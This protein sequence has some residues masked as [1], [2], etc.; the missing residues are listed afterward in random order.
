MAPATASGEASLLGL[1]P[2]LRVRIYDELI[3][4]QDHCIKPVPQS[5]VTRTGCCRN[6]WALPQ[7][8]TLVR[9]EV[10][11]MLPRIE[12]LSFEIK[13]FSHRALGIWLEQL[14]SERV[15]LIRRLEMDGEGEFIAN[16]HSCANPDEDCWR[17]V[18]WFDA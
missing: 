5:K 9:N 1:P 17:F 15:L 18:R 6:V 8:C 10:L 11:P 4:P 13:N 12:A 14:G 3:V 7:V 2:E 16:T